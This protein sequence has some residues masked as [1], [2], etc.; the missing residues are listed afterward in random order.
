M[1]DPATNTCYFCCKWK[2]KTRPLYVCET[3]ILEKRMS[4]YQF[5]LCE[6]CLK[7][8]HKHHQ[9]PKAQLYDPQVLKEYIV[10]EGC[11]IEE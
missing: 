9:N 4:N 1:I 10:R 6:D 5:L 3:C 11:F 2:N 7:E 8:H